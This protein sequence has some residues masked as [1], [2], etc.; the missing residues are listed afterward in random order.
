MADPS[1]EN[2]WGIER[3]AEYLSCSV[4]RAYEISASVGFPRGSIGGRARRF[5]PSLVRAWYLR[6]NGLS[7]EDGQPAPDRIRNPKGKEKHA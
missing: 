2:L 1:Q 7:L 6:V 4:S 5:K 3:L